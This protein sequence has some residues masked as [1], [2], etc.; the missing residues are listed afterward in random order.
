MEFL[1]VGQIVRTI[2]LKGEVKIYPSTHFR[3]TRFSKGSR[4]F[5]LNDKNEIE[6]ELTIKLHRTNGDCDNLIFEEISTIEEAEK[7]NQKFLYVEKDQKFLRNGEFFYTD[8]VG[9]T[10]EFDNGKTIGKVIKIEEYNSYATLRVKT[11]EKDVLI[12]FVQAFVKSVSLEEKKI[13]VNYIEG[14]L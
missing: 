7:I 8:L 3:D 13:I 2:G 5:L 14:L 4:V 9:M 12:P 1:T 10:C 11:T 6:R